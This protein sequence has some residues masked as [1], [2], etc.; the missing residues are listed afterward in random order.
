METIA[1]RLHLPP[2]FRMIPISGKTDVERLENARKQA[3]MW[4]ENV[5]KYFIE[6]KDYPASSAY[7]FVEVL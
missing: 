2:K 7:L 6:R 3:E 1:S 4:P 5:R